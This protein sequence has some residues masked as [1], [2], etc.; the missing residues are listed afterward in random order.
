M[1]RRS[2]GTERK[3]PMPMLGYDIRITGVRNRKF[4]VSAMVMHDLSDDVNVGT[5][6]L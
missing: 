4:T 5:G 1:E 2:V 6:F 3:S